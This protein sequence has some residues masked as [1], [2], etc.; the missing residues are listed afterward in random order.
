MGRLNNRARIEGAPNDIVD[1]SP[2][3]T[4]DFGNQTSVQIKGSHRR[5]SDIHST[6]LRSS[7]KMNRAVVGVCS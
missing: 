3:C 5:L 6:F 2:L 1:A 4:S 7:S